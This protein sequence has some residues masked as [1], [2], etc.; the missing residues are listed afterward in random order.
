[1]SNPTEAPTRELA[2]FTRL[3]TPTKG[4]H[5]QHTRSVGVGR[6]RAFLLWILAFAPFVTLSVAEALCVRVQVTLSLTSCF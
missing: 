4:K 2:E 3:F 1:M 5:T 6:Q